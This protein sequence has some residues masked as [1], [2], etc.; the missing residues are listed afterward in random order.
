MEELVTC[1]KYGAGNT[2]LALSA[3]GNGVAVREM[4]GAAHI[5][6]GY[7]LDDTTNAAEAPGSQGREDPTE[8]ILSAVESLAGRLILGTPYATGIAELDA[9]TEKMWPS[10]MKSASL[11]LRKLILGVPVIIRFHN[12]ADGSSGAVALSRAVRNLSERLGLKP[13]PIWIMHRSVMYTGRDLEWD[14]L[15]A[16]NY[17]SIEK[18]LLFIIDFGTSENSNQGI[19]AAAGHLDVIWLDHHPIEEGFKGK[20]LEHYI[21]P[22]QFGSGSNYTAGYLACAF[23]H[24]FSEVET[25][26]MEGASLIGDCSTFAPQAKSGEQ[27]AAL[28]DLLT[29][30]PKVISKA[31]G[32][33][34][35]SE[36]DGILSDSSR[37]EELCNYAKV[38]L[39]ETLDKAFVQAKH[40]RAGKHEIIVLDYGEIRSEDTRYPLPGRF[41]SKL[42]TEA[43]KNGGKHYLA[44]VHYNQFISMRAAG[45]VSD[46]VN[47]PDIIYQMKELYLSG[48]DSGGGHKNAASIKVSIYGDKKE[49]LRSVIEM[50]RERLQ[51]S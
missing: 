21:N 37:K 6:A 24:V 42:L 17:G 4:E 50:A 49:I 18:P 28:L 23:S 35:P 11:L 8:S 46:A 47:I 41:A 14:M 33:L 36:I 26:D 31:D 15:V 40:V 2:C 30:D 5:K 44:I 9:T 39:E 48:I 10:F 7:I 3:S 13:N 38:K 20:S 22:W 34:T 45:E 25:K 43:D 16:N 1:I 19:D 29:S 32:N 51:S 27:E 12:D